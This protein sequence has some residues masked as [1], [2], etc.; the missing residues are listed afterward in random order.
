MGNTQGAYLHV[1]VL[2]VL[3]AADAVGDVQVDELGGQRHHG[4]QTVHHL[5]RHSQSNRVRS[6]VNNLFT[7]WRDS[8]LSK[9]CR[10]SL[11]K[12]MSPV[13]TQDLT[14]V[15]RDPPLKTMM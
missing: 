7:E 10:R 5:L 1:L 15:L 13:K 4:H 8:K 2:D 9:R 6:L 12:S 3:A 14:W 11:A